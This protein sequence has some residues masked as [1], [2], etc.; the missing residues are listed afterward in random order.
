MADRKGVTGEKS[1]RSRN[2][3]LSALVQNTTNKNIVTTDLSG[4][5]DSAS[6]ITLIQSAN[7]SNR[8]A[9]SINSVHRITALAE[10]N[11]LATHTGLGV[12]NGTAKVGDIAYKLNP[13]DG[14]VLTNISAA[15]TYLSTGF[16]VQ[17]DNGAVTRMHF[18]VKPAGQLPSANF[19]IG[20]TVARSLAGASAVTVTAVSDTGGNYSKGYLDFTPSVSGYPP[21]WANK[22][23]YVS[24]A[25][26]S[27]WKTL[28][29]DSAIVVQLIDSSY[30]QARQTA[31]GGGVDSAATLALINKRIGD[32]SVTSAFTYTYTATASQ[33]T[34]TGNDDNNVSL[35][36][37]EGAIQAF[38]N[39]V[40]LVDSADY[41]ASTGTSLVLNTGATVGDVINI[42]KFTGAANTGTLSH[43]QFKYLT[44][45][46]QSTISGVDNNNKTLTYNA[47]EIQVYLN[48]ILLIDSD[49]YVA[50]NGTSIVLT[51]A[52]DSG[53]MVSISK[54]VP[55]SGGMA[56]RSENFVYTTGSP[57][58]NITGQ[59]DN[60]L[61]LS[62]IQ[63]QI[64]VFRNGIMLIDSADYTA[65]NGTH[66]VLNQATNAADTVAI[67]AFR[68][69]LTGGLDSANITNLIDS[70]YIQSKQSSGGGGGGVTNAD[71]IGAFA[72]SPVAGSLHYAINKKALYLYDGNEYDRIFS[73][74]NETITWDSDLTSTG[75]LNGPIRRDLGVTDSAITTLTFSAAEDF[76]GFPIVYSYEMVP[77]YPKQLDS[78]YGD[79]SGSGGKGLIDS[80]THPTRPRISLL[81][82]ANDSD[83]GSFIFRIKASDGTHVISSS[84]TITLAFTVNVVFSDASATNSAKRSITGLSAGGQSINGWTH[85]H[86]SL[87]SGSGSVIGDALAIGKK[88]LELEVLAGCQIGA[89][90][91]LTTDQTDQGYST[92]TKQHS[93][94][95]NNG[96]GYGVAYGSALGAMNA[97]GT[98][99]MVAWDT[100]TRKIWFGKNGTW[101]GDPAAGTGGA[102][103]NGNA[104][105]PFYFHTGNGSSSNGQQNITVR[106]NGA[107]TY[108]IP[109]GF[110][111][112]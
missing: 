71:S 38:Q 19:A 102:T 53:D 57:T 48:G 79:D 99:I 70:S 31:G 62:Y 91:G 54:F 83:E 85:D 2:R 78:A 104:G 74:S 80:S 93:R 73:G 49:D 20:N 1:Y 8:T 64:Q 61:T 69:V 87:T 72:A 88:Y 3:A 105:D 14:Y 108:T 41:V 111:S 13:F 16:H 35:R 7:D 89:M 12:L 101:L 34:F 26:Q 96:N 24:V 92:A 18:D 81:P 32:S 45:T 98:R 84:Q 77:R 51:S 39:G 50:T 94:Y 17:T 42:T 97:A 40:L 109:T 27:T 9:G 10:L 95:F 46:P 59:D 21:I 37:N 76:E 65:T 60:S 86:N 58:T 103:L 11:T 82:S 25:V 67:T 23:V 55:G 75:D 100:T 52:T 66:I 43:T 112:Q 47:G 33:T 5:T 63:D 107:E 22:D 56:F 36:Y 90:I 30:I 15:A 68:G 6:I 29:I 28:G 106:K 44:A 110:S 4:G